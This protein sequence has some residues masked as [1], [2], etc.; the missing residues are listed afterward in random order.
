M[1]SLVIPT[2]AELQLKLI[3]R[4]SCQAPRL[5]QQCTSQPQKTIQRVVAERTDCETAEIVRQRCKIR[6]NNLY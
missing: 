5:C 3:L 1:T 4:S 6:W 2:V